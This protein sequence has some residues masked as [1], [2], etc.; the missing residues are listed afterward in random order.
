LSDLPFSENQTETE[1][2]YARV[3]RNAGQVLD[4]FF[5]QR[6]DAVFR[7]PA[8]TESAERDHRA[9]LDILNRLLR[10]LNDL[11]DR[12]SRQIA[13]A[14]PPPM[15]IPATPFLPAPFSRSCEIS[16]ITIRAPLAPIG[17]PSEMAP[18]QALSFSRGIPNSFCAASATTAN[19]SFTSKRSTLEASHPAFFIARLIASA[20]AVV[21]Q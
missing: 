16:V 5:D 4:P 14:S 12:L 17:C 9:V 1:V 18:P 11:H 19:A 20:G 8:K 13:V 10:V 21:N 15:Q 7:D 3:F 6:S 2:I